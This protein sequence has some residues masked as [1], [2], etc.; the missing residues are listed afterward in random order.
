MPEITITGIGSELQGVGRLSDGRAVFVPYT[1]PNERVHIEITRETPRFAEARLIEIIEP[2]ADRIAPACPYYGVCGGCVAQHMR[3]AASLELKRQKVENALKRIGGVG[4]PLVLPTIG[5]DNVY[6]CRNKAEYAVEIHDGAPVVGLREAKSRRVIPIG[7]CLLQTESSVRIMR[8]MRKRLAGFGE[9]KHIRY[10]VTR[11]NRKGELTLTISCDAPLFKQISKLTDG[12]TEPISVYFCRLNPHPTHALDGVCTRVR[13]AETPS[14]ELL[15]LTFALSPQS[16]FQ[17]NP[18]QAER[19]Y[20]KAFEAIDL[21]ESMRLLDAYCGA[22]T[23]SLTAARL[24]GHVTGVEIVAPAIENA[25]ENAMRNGLTDRAAFICGDAAKVI[26]KRIADGERFDAAILDPPRKGADRALLEA[27]AKVE[28][29]RIVYISCDPATLA[30]DVKILSANGYSF[31]WAQPV[32][33]FP[34]TEHVES[35]VLMSRA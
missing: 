20:R 34:W 2:S 7:D 15:G 30:R 4:E 14:D 12:L 9:A 31:Q 11:T 35:V 17:V 3:Y 29:P 28:I 24:C 19:L 33:M 16:F 32:D 27:L 21:N 13:G 6:R 25:K 1:L 8:E 18:R 26:P 10:L 22:G 5:S 23:I